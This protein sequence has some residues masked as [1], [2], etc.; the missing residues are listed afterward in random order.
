MVSP[1][2]P[3]LVAVSCEFIG[4]GPTPGGPHSRYM[5]LTLLYRSVGSLCL[6]SEGMGTCVRWTYC[7][8]GVPLNLGLGSTGTGTG[9]GSL[10]G[11]ADTG[12]CR[13]PISRV[14]RRPAYPFRKNRSAAVGA[15]IMPQPCCAQPPLGPHL[16]VHRSAGMI[17]E[18]E[19]SEDTTSTAHC[20]C[21]AAPLCA[22]THAA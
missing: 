7:L 20:A 15:G 17:Y 3:L 8:V 4:I 19:C 12:C 1:R 11:K 14:K 5:V 10:S 18:V 9:T 21:T 13:S 6:S 22:F 2:I 16:A